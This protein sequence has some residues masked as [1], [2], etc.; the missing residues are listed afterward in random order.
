MTHDFWCAWFLGDGES[1]LRSDCSNEW[2]QGGIFGVRGKFTPNLLV[3]YSLWNCHILYLCHACLFLY[4]CLVAVSRNPHP[5][6]MHKKRKKEK[7][8]RKRNKNNHHKT[9]PT[10]LNPIKETV[11]C[12]TFAVLESSGWFRLPDPMP[13]W[14]GK[15]KIKKWLRN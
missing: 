5:A 11:I 9:T 12:L 15:N 8:K 2:G 10:S 1:K 4:P 3:A 14:N 13:R 7:R 6:P